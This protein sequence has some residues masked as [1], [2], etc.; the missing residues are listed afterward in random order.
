MPVRP[1][2]IRPPHRG[3]TVTLLDDNLYWQ[4]GDT[5]EIT[6]RT[7]GLLSIDTRGMWYSNGQFVG[8]GPT[9]KPTGTGEVIT[10]RHTFSR[11]F[12]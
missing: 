9:Y 7:D 2:I 3:L 11:Q 1:I 6:N 10:L 5:I 12:P 8:R 4:D